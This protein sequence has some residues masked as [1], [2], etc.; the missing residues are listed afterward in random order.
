MPAKKTTGTQYKYVGNYATVLEG[1]QPLAPGDYISLDA[2]A[3]TA[4]HY[5]IDDGK[6]IDA[7]GVNVPEESSTE[8]QEASA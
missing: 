7:S 5:L 6:L 1:G 2:D 8:Q 4:N 3:M